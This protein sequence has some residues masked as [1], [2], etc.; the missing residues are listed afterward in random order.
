MENDKKKL[1]QLFGQTF[2][3]EDLSITR[4]TPHKLT[5]NFKDLVKLVRGKTA[6]PFK[7][8]QKTT[9]CKTNYLCSIRRLC[10]KIVLVIFYQ[11]VWWRRS[12]ESENE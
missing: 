6:A 5:N 7:L 4:I 9:K 12:D 1:Q 8:E 2:D 11:K 10:N 3:F